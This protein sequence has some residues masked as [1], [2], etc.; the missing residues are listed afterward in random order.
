[1]YVEHLRI[2]VNGDTLHVERLGRGGSAVVLVHGFGTNASLWRPVSARLANAGYL[3]LAPDL[4]GH[5]ESDRPLDA[6]YDFASQADVLERALSALRIGRAVVVGQDVG[7]VVGLA[8]ASRHPARVARLVMLNPPDLTDLPPAPVRVMQ[9]AA[10]RLALGVS[11][12]RLGAA[13]LISALLT[14][15]IA[16]PAGLPPSALARYLA[17]WAGPGGVEQLQ[18]LARALEGDHVSL[19]ALSGITTPTLIVRG[20]LDR[21]VPPTVAVALAR[22]LPQATLTTMPTSARV[23][24]EDAPEALTKVLLDW[25]QD[26]TSP[27]TDA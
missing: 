21:S 22:A 20:A 26:T 16:D 4:L 14:D 24:A 12:S 13:A 19:E 27:D 15:A 18:V 6:S 1:M 23:L 10:S 11:S 9:K 8:L 3:V 5:G 2:P 7:A 25:M 17:P